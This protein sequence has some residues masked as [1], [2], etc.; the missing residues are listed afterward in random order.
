M[1]ENMTGAL[2]MMAAMAAFTIN[3]TM[4]KATG[5]EVP[6]F[7]LLFLRG[8]LASVLIF[9]LAR[10]RARGSLRAPISRR[11]GVLIGIRSLAEVGAA[12]FFLSALFHMPLAN[13]SAV[14]QAL[15]LTVTLASAIFLRERVGWR[16]L[17]AILIGFIGMLLILR[18]GPEGFSVWS[19]YA[20]LAVACVTV[21][22]L[23]VRRMS[24]AVSSIAVTLAASLTVTIC[25]G[26]AAGT[27]PWVPVDGANALLIAGSAVFI[28]GGYYTS[29]Q[30]MRHGDISYIAP[31]RYTSLLWALLLGWLVFGDW[32]AP[33]TLLGAAIIVATGLF[34]LYRERKVAAV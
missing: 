1:S 17:L 30:V 34:T 31:F 23:S 33:L 8:L 2:L 28:V 4:L 25:A 26:L 18:P 20:L 3:D 27:E 5:G 32:P 9:V 10:A 22:D 29:V 6:L 24:P 12:Y 14:L 13:V 16:R 15:P 19:I 21:R 11:D 7:Q